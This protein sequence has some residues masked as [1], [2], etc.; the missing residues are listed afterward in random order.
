MS[1][2]FI[3][4]FYIEIFYDLINKR[5]NS[6]IYLTTSYIQIYYISNPIINPCTK[7]VMP[8]NIVGKLIINAIIAIFLFDFF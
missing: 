1:M 3:V 4:F 2:V 5:Y 8:V 6:N 7:A